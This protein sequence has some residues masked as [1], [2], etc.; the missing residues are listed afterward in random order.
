MHAA[1]IRNTSAVSGSFETQLHFKR[2]T[3][4]GLVLFHFDSKMNKS[5]YI[6]LTV[7]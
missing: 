5:D 2:N 7:S 3:F 6:T 1:I 4:K